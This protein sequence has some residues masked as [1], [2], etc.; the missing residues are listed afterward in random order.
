MPP[1]Q[2]VK[3][4]PKN[5]A[6]LF[7]NGAPTKPTHWKS[8]CCGECSHFVVTDLAPFGD[9]TGRVLYRGSCG[10]GH[11]C[12]PY[13]ASM[14]VLDCTDFDIKEMHELKG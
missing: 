8:N 1:V 11:R 10:L 6:V 4:Q 9:G 5:K 2:K 3:E 13:G 14:K 12:G 7:I